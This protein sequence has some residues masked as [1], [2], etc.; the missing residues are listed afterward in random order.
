MLSLPNKHFI[1]DC[2]V[3]GLKLI[4]RIVHCGVVVLQLNGSLF[5]LMNL[6]NVLCEM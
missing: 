2:L 5:Y 3:K 1:S 4:S 6:A